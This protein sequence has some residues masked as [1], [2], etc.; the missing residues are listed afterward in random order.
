MNQQY[1]DSVI[2]HL[3]AAVVDVYAHRQA[4][5][6]PNVQ[7]L[8]HAVSDAKRILSALSV[9]LADVEDAEAVAS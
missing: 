7:Q 5:K 3:N 1:V 8:L 6:N 9:E 2:S 4:R